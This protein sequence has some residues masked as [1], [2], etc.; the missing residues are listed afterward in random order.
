MMEVAHN[1]APV[2]TILE[3]E[4]NKAADTGAERDDR[5]QTLYRCTLGIDKRLAPD[6][7]IRR[8]EQQEGVLRKVRK[9][10]P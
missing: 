3:E 8:T 9:T 5:C 2:A 1:I 7:H 6:E 4:T 10:S